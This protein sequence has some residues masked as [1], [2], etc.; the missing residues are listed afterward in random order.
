VAKTTLNE[1][2]S[3]ASTYKGEHAT[4]QRS[5]CFKN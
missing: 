5:G 2:K 1:L 3:K 4:F